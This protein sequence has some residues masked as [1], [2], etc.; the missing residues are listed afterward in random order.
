[1][2]QG[3]V[4]SFAVLLHLVFRIIL[5]NRYCSH[6]HLGIVLGEVRVVR[7]WSNLPKAK[8]IITGELGFESRSEVLLGCLCFSQNRQAIIIRL[9]LICIL[10]GRLFS[11]LKPDLFK[12]LLRSFNYSFSIKFLF[13]YSYT[14]SLL[15]IYQQAFVTH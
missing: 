15:N 6:S 4:K 7:G 12:N 8:L 14:F 1:M 13:S 11:F 9:T 5:W 3:W 2:Y 10:A